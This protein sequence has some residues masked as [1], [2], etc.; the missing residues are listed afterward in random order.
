M[1]VRI[2]VEDGE[3]ILQALARLEI[4]V[5]IAYRCRLPKRSFAYFEKPSSRDRTRAFIRWEN[6]RR[7]TILASMGIRYCATNRYQSWRSLLGETDLVREY[8]WNRRRVARAQAK[9]KFNDRQER[10]TKLRHLAS[11]RLSSASEEI[12]ACFQGW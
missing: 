5:R 1:P 8:K 3:S 4:K 2:F 6:A 12:R 11:I 9:R 10:E 7:R